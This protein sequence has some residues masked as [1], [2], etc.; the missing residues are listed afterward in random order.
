MAGRVKVRQPGGGGRRSQQVVRQRQQAARVR[1]V[2]QCAWYGAQCRKYPSARGR[3]PFSD[4][5]CYS[6]RL[7]RCCY[8]AR[9]A[10]GEARQVT[11]TSQ[12]LPVPSCAQVWR[13]CACGARKGVR[14][15][16][17]VCRQPAVVREVRG[18]A[19]PL[20]VRG[21]GAEARVQWQWRVPRRQKVAQ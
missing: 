5:V 8:G 12:P 17:A 20:Y 15:G 16:G 1:A 21:G 10:Q 14:C 6:V 18:C 2:Q 7:R 13:E 3:R 9:M 11:K 4:V 19:R